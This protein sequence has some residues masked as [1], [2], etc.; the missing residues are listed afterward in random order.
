MLK[1]K[2]LYIVLTKM[3]NLQSKIMC[4]IFCLVLSGGSIYSMEP[5]YSFTNIGIE[6]GLSQST[7]FDIMQ[8]SKGFIWF[9]TNNGLNRYDGYNFKV[10]SS[11]VFDS[12]SISDNGVTA[13]H[14]DN[15][16]IMW[17]GTKQGALNKYNYKTDSFERFYFNTDTLHNKLNEK[18]Y[19]ES[20][21]A[22]ARNSSSTISTIAEDE[23][24]ILDYINIELKAR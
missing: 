12:S 24:G 18:L 22:F 20:L 17:V 9:A 1:N 23:Y 11:S 10:Y 19:N 8:D 4:L 3:K 13:L 16:G 2:T 6:D 15:D 7:I 5:E 21:I 14:K